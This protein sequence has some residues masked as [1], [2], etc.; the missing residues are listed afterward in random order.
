MEV[1][2]IIL[3]DRVKDSA[4]NNIRSGRYKGLKHRKTCDK[5]EKKWYISVHLF[6]SYT[7]NQRHN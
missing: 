4:V 2:T 6:L 1:S 3:L 7:C 5:R